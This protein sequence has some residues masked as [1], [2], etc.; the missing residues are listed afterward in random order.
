MM[1]DNGQIGLTHA[2]QR[3]VGSLTNVRFSILAEVK[4]DVLDALSKGV[5]RGLLNFGLDAF[6]PVAVDE[7]K[8]AG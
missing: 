2:K 4:D 1:L 3:R 5:N 6:G 7:D 8:E